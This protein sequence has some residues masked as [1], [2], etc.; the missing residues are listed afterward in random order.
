MVRARFLRMSQ[1]RLRGLLESCLDRLLPLRGASPVRAVGLSQL[2]GPA[3]VMHRVDCR[4]GPRPPRVALALRQ[5][6]TA[7]QQID[8]ALQEA[9]T[10]KLSKILQQ[11]EEQKVRDARH[12]LDVAARRLRARSSGNT[13]RSIKPSITLCAAFIRR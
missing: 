13:T 11:V 3:I 10:T 5:V 4:R 8:A 1:L 6:Q 2:R 9:Q 7:S 12:L